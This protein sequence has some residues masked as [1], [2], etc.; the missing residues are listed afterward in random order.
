MYVKYTFVWIPHRDI[1]V[2]STLKTVPISALC[3]QFLLT[4]IQVQLTRT[5]SVVTGSLP[6]KGTAHIMKN[7]REVKGPRKVNTN[8]IIFGGAG[9]R[10]SLVMR[11]LSVILTLQPKFLNR[12][13]NRS[14]VDL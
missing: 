13:I 3:S 4:S 6:K 2:V 14:Y 7:Q 9:G 11:G 1:V 5:P 8:A 12:A 10:R